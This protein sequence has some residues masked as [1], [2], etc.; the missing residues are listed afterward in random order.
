MLDLKTFVKETL[1]QID[2]A[3]LEASWEFQTHNYKFWKNASWNTSIDFEVQVYAS[4]WTGTNGWLWI[5][6]AWFKVWADGK[7]ENSNSQLSKISFSIVRENTSEQNKKEMQ[8]FSNS[9]PPMKTY[10]P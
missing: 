5:S 6:V 7:S 10:S 8:E 3:L 2:W 9:F 4:E 1:L